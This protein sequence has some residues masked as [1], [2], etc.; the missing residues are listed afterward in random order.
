M[1][2]KN[3]FLDYLDL[4]KGL[5]ERET[6]VKRLIIK[7]LECE[8]YEEASTNFKELKTITGKINLIEKMEMKYKY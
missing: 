5:K 6:E 4:Y 8:E 2:K 3:T 7:N 1:L